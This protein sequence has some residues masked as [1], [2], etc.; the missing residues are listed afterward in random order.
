M[1]HNRIYILTTLALMILI[2]I[3]ACAAEAPAEPADSIAP[4]STATE[5]AFAPE[6]A[7]ET[8]PPVEEPT[9]T[10]VEVEVEAA[11]TVSF[12]TDILPI[13]ESRCVNCHGGERVE[14]GLYLRTYDEIMTGSE[15]GPVVI[16]GNPEESSLVEVV[17]T[18]EM[19]KRGPKLTPVQVQL[20]SD[21]VAAGAPNN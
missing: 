18:Q 12:S 2:G 15:N 16:P 1:K 9:P 17:V 5:P 3:T 19:P 10:G 20:L 7:A 4:Q 11:T 21:W 8:A 6:E 14:D 13:M